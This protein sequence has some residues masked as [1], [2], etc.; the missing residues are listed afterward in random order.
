M[1]LVVVITGFFKNDLWMLADFEIYYR[2]RDRIL[3]DVLNVYVP[4]QIL[5]VQVSA[6]S[7]Y[8]RGSSR[9]R[10]KL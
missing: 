10:W 4:T 5:S 1:T 6:K 2:N 3:N 7:L 8:L 9:R